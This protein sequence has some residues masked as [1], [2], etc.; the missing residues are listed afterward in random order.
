MRDSGTLSPKWVHESLPISAQRVIQKRKWEDYKKPDSKE[1][2][3]T[4]QDQHTLKL[5]E[6]AAHAQDMNRFKSGGVLVLS[7]GYRHGNP[8]LTKKLSAADTHQQRKH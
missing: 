1:I 6:T 8:P 7:W 4:Q 2:V 5:T 3:L